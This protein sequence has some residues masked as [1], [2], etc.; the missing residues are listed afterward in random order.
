MKFCKDCKHFRDHSQING[1]MRGF[2][3]YRP[4][5]VTH[6]PVTG[7]E[8]SK[9]ARSCHDERRSPWPGSCGPDAD[10]FDPTNQSLPPVIGIMLP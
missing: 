6:D 10:F 8:I 9:P 5:L 2:Y 4:G 1:A 7:E 3:C